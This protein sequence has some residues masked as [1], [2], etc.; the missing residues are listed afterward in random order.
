VDDTKA[1]VLANY[2]VNG[3]RTA[4]TLDLTP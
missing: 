4:V 1:V 2:D 3:N